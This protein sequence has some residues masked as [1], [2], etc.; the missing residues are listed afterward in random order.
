MKKYSIRRRVIRM[1]LIHRLQRTPQHG[2]LKL[3]IH[4][5]QHLRIDIVRVETHLVLSIIRRRTMDRPPVAPS[6]YSI[7]SRC[8]SIEKERENSHAPTSPAKVERQFLVAPDI[9]LRDRILFGLDLDF[10]R[11]IV[12]PSCAVA[13]ADCALAVVDVRR[14]ARDGDGDGAAVAG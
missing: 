12:A 9:L 7:S 5:P 14:K 8:Q 4:K 10:V 13:A 1:L 3:P 11:V 2:K 6:M